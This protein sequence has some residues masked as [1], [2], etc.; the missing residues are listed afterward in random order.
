MI[1]RKFVFA[2]L[3]AA[4]VYAQLSS[5]VRRKVGALLV[6]G[7]TPIAIGYNGTRPGECNCCEDENGNTKPG[8]RHAE[9]NALNKL[10]GSRETAKEAVLFV[11]D[12]PCPDCMDDL[13]NAGVR[14]VFYLR[15]YRLMDHMLKYVQQGCNFY[16]VDL[17]TKII[18]RWYSEQIF[19]EIILLPK[20]KLVKR[21]Y[22]DELIA[23]TSLQV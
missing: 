23:T 13:F 2:H 12:S 17:D 14:D 20:Y 11:T 15:E 6:K 8:V 18:C 4:K 22:S 3:E 5:C 19:R 10:W 1:K 7:G 21:V 16:H 9:I